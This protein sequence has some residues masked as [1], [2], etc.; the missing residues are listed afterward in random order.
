MRK[1]ILCLGA[2]AFATACAGP[3]AGNITTSLRPQ[4]APISGPGS[5]AGLDQ[6]LAGF[7]PR[8]E[9]QGVSRAVLDRSLSGV[10]YN[11][12]VIR[13]DGNQAEF[14][15]TVWEYLAGAVSQSRI[16]QGRAALARH[17]AVLDRIEAQYGVDKEIVVAV[18]GMESNYGTNRGSMDLFNS[19]ATLAYHGRRGPFF[20]GELIAALKIVQA[21]DVAPDNMT[22]SWAGAMGH[23]QFMP[24]SYLT[25]AVD[26]T[27]DGR[28]DIWS[29]DPT[30][31]LASTAAYLARS[32][33]QRGGIWGM[34][35]VLPQ[36]FDY[37]QV[38]KTN[39]LSAQAWAGQ[40]VRAADG[41]SL[42]S[43]EASVLLPG[44]ANGAAFLIYP[45]FRAIERYN[46]ADSYVIGVG[47]LADRLRGLGPIQRQAPA[48]RALSRGERTELQERLTR[49]GFDTQGT[50]GRI[51]PNTIAAITA[52]Q[53][54][55]GLIPDGYASASLLASLR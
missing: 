31:A 27:G 14:T 29:N 18:W 32:G 15:K 3:G 43:G 20:E 19:L 53:R 47:H 52:Y 49:A 36:G 33:W 8:A 34:E 1:M 22:G 28:R 21:G 48:E 51:G 12:E 41:R 25:H 26:F 24:T 16:E 45:N 55:R 37:G 44:G 13:L 46:A 17:G 35:V 6:W 5:Q 50:D 7:R 9:A 23:T 40:G 54:N 30:D 42:P 4:S 38:G 39:R 2:M 10:T 11:P